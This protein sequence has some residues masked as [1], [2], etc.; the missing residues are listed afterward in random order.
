MYFDND[1]YELVDQ[2]F[3][4]IILMLILNPGQAV[5]VIWLSFFFQNLNLLPG[6]DG[7]EVS[8]FNW[9]LLPLLLL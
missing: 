8:G 5:M 4:S 7:Q 9:F 2:S 3:F 1:N 6:H